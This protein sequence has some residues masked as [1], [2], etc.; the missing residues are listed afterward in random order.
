MSRLSGTRGIILDGLHMPVTRGQ[1][2][3]PGPPL[4][5]T[6]L[7]RRCGC[8][9]PCHFVRHIGDRVRRR[10]HLVWR[11]TFR[12]NVISALDGPPQ[13]HPERIVDIRDTG[14][15]TDGL[16][17][18]A[19]ERLELAS[20]ERRGPGRITRRLPGRDRRLPRPA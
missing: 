9:V 14:V 1:H 17:E 5:A 20:H 10:F 12:T 3:G 7:A 15:G 8:P 6:R 19:D 2:V 16:V 18:L 4:F 11:A 13:P